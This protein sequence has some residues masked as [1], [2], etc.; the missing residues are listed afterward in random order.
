MAQVANELNISATGLTLNHPWVRALAQEASGPV[1]MGN[2]H[3]QGGKI[4][5]PYATVGPV[6]NP[7]ILFGYPNLF[8]G[9][10]YELSSLQTGSGGTGMSLTMT[11]A[12][13]TDG[14]P[15]LIQPPVYT[16]NFLVLNQ[17]A[18]HQYVLSKVAGGV[19]AFNGAWDPN[20]VRAGATADVFLIV[21][22]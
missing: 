18:G 5:G 22:N 15:T 20:I 6:G 19:W 8:G 10:V 1:S 11:F 16:G 9:L 4:N 13:T 21:P 2:L 12:G 14:G 3:G 7:T 17:S